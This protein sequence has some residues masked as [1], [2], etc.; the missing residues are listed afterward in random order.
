MAGQLPLH[1]R[2]DIQ[3]HLDA[4]AVHFKAPKITLLVRPEVPDGLDADLVMT[5][6]TLPALIE[7]LKR[8]HQLDPERT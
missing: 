4:I 7:A 6:D 2:L 5:N 3:A 1:I 8:R